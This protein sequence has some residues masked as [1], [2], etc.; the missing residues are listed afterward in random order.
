MQTKESL[1]A[2]PVIDR[3]E[4]E[5]YLKTALD[6]IKAGTAVFREKFPFSSSVH[7]FYPVSENVEWTTGFWTGQIWQAYR[8]TKDRELLETADLQVDSFLERIENNIDTNHHDM[9]F[10]Y[11]PSCAAAYELT[12][13]EK[14]KKA[15]L[16]AADRLLERFQEKGQFFQAWGDPG[17]EENYRLIIDCLMNMPLLFWATGQ[18]G[19]P[20]YAQKARAHIQTAMECL[21]RPD[22][23]TYHTC[24]FDKETGKPLRGVTHQGNR[25]GSAWARGQAWGIYGSAVAYEALQNSSYIDIFRR[26]TE[27]FLTH[28]PSDLIPYW[29]FDFDDG[30]S[31]PRDSSAAAI[32][33][34]GML[35]MAEFL[36]EEEAAY[37]RDMAGRLVKALTRTCAVHGEKEAGGLI[38]HGTY[39][40]AS[41]N[42]PC[43]NVGVDE[44]NLWG[45]YY[46]LEALI[47]LRE[48]KQVL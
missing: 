25:D 32:A 33:A 5:K 29:D 23:S 13:S 30:S 17:T 24:F 35:K 38:L 47:K 11:M 14:G 27:F 20:L 22:D 28:L 31:E 41:K 4:T 45:D 42:N 6:L 44:C 43:R 8:L 36:E 16:L 12:G 39:A 15:A 18:T 1:S 40:R 2:Y 46:Y 48:L 3:Q 9:G 37:Y 19:N 10:L 34:C 21:I 7:G 26:V